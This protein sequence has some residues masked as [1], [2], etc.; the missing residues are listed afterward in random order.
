MN[1]ALPDDK[2]LTFANRSVIIAQ[3]H[4]ELRAYLTNLQN[5]GAQ[6]ATISEVL[7]ILHS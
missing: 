1:D 5:Q 3:T 2:L 6:T 7:A 4:N